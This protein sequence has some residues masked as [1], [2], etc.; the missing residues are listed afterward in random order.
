[1]IRRVLLVL[2]SVLFLIFL[3]LFGVLAI[4]FL[5]PSETAR[6]R[7]TLSLLETSAAKFVPGIFLQAEHIDEIVEMN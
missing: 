4:V 2:A 3:T 6:D 5:G 7:L 1:M